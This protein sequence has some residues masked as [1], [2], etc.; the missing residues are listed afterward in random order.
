MSLCCPCHRL[1]CHKTDQ[2]NYVSQIDNMKSRLSCRNLILFTLDGHTF[3]RLPLQ[4]R[5]VTENKHSTGTGPADTPRNSAASCWNY[6]YFLPLSFQNK[7]G[8]ADYFS[9]NCGSLTCWDKYPPSSILS[10]SSVVLR[11]ARA[12]LLS[13]A[14]SS[15]RSILIFAYPLRWEDGWSVLFLW[16]CR[17]T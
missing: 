14:S 7:C 6:G 2:I 8:F 16:Y 9:V 3:D 1:I 5:P 17:V 12:W 15:W 13:S 10:S 11:A 4:I